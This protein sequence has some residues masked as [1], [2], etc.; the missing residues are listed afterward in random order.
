MPVR[1]PG[2]NILGGGGRH[3]DPC[4]GSRPGLSGP[5]TR[6]CRVDGRAGDEGREVKEDQILGRLGGHIERRWLLLNEKSPE[7][8][9]SRG[10][11]G[12][13]WHLSSNQTDNRRLFYG[14]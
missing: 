8:F 12:S 10:V 5:E 1:T 6:E 9:L 2:E 14:P 7:E 11:I 13:L 4:H 3:A